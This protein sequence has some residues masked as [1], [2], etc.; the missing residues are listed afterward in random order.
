MSTLLLSCAAF[1][2]ALS[3]FLALSLAMDRHHEDAYGRGSTP[4]G[5]RPWLRGVG[6]VL[7]LASLA[8]SLT[9]EGRNQGWVLWAGV[10]T[11]AALT[12]A[13]IL[14]YWPERAFCIG[15][16][17]ALTSVGCGVVWWA[18]IEPTNADSHTERA[19]G[20]NS[21]AIAQSCGRQSLPCVMIGRS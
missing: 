15:A 20:P 19:T 1:I 4:G 21:L 5:R 10:L 3:G 7:L 16:L 6:I 9:L 2:G 14:C 12:V 8:T 13:V 11:C 17:G 18:L